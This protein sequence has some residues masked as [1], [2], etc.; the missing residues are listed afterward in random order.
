MRV[1]LRDPALGLSPSVIKSAS[2]EVEVGDGRDGVQIC[3]NDLA[4]TK[5]DLATVQFGAFLDEEMP[6]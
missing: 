3:L 2:A 5:H 6:I 4:K 1:G